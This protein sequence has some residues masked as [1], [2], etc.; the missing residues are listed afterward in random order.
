MIHMVGLALFWAVM[1]EGRQV[2]L[3]PLMKAAERL[4]L[5]LT[6]AR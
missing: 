3:D 6:L 1:R 4:M 2:L 5:A